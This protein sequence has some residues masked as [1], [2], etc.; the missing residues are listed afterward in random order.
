[1][2]RHCLVL[3]LSQNLVFKCLDRIFN[4]DRCRGGRRRGSHNN[5]CRDWSW[6]WCC[7][8]LGL[9][10]GL[11][12]CLWLWAVLAEGLDRLASLFVPSW[13][14]LGWHDDVVGL[15]DGLGL[16]RILL[17]WFFHHFDFRNFHLFLFFDDFNVIVTAFSLF[18][19]TSD[20][21]LVLAVDLSHD[22]FTVDLGVEEFPLRSRQAHWVNLDS[23]HSLSR[24]LSLNMWADSGHISFKVCQS[25]HLALVKID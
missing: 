16:D 22:G 9:G 10:S 14:D 3:E 24:C 4:R 2:A 23:F 1:M 20:S 7:D 6:D 11:W 5:W 12:C 21:M 25:L 18:G 17:L 13:G 15:L 19:L 8:W